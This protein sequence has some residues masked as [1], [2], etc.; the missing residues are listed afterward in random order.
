MST[1]ADL[2]GQ[3][4]ATALAFDDAKVARENLALL[5]YRP[6]V[7]AAAVSFTM[8]QGRAVRRPIFAPPASTTRFPAVAAG[9]RRRGR[10]RGPG[11]LQAHRRQGRQPRHGLS[12]VDR[13]RARPHPR[14]RRH[15]RRPGAARRVLVAVRA[16]CSSWSAAKI[17]TRPIPH[18]HDRRGGGRRRRA[19][20]LFAPRRADQQRR[21]RPP[22]RFVQPDDG[23]DREPREREPGRAAGR[24]ARGERAAPGPGGGDA[25]ERGPREPRRRPHGGAGIVQPRPRPGQ[26]DG[27]ECQPRQVG[28]PLQHEPRAAHAAERHHG[29]RAIAGE[30][31]HR[32][33]RGQ[34]PGIHAPHRQRRQPSAGPDHREILDLARIT[35]SSNVMLSLEPVAIDD[36]LQECRGR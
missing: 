11:A 12:P 9:R 17:V 26:P 6:Q 22:R 15:R 33:A 7:R 25:A 23:R 27:R 19:G 31:H 21:G 20:R 10:R 36:V 14:L 5:H 16:S 18:G 2:L 30:R 1:Q 24:R 28:V 13:Q 4:S 32:A 8:C 29:L 35:E 34:A 3:S